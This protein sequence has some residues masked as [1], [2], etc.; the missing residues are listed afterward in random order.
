MG[1]LGPAI[2]YAHRP[3][4]STIFKNALPWVWPSVIP[5]LG[6]TTLLSRRGILM[7]GIWKCILQTARAESEA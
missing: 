3:F 5:S 2:R 6:E 4:A 7:A 1:T